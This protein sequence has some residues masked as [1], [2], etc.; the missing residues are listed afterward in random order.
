MNFSDFK[1]LI[2]PIKRKIFLSLGR[3]IL[4]AINNSEG[5]QKIQVIALSGETIT[6][7]ERFQEYGFET[8]PFI[9]AE[10]FAAFLNGN[11]DHGIVLCVHDR[12]YRPTDLVEGE[13]CNY[14]DE[15]QESGGHRIH[16][17]RGQIIEI[18]CKQ[19]IIN[20]VDKA[21]INTKQ[22][23]INATVQAKVTSPDTEVTGGTVKLA[24]QAGM[25]K[26]LNDNFATLYDGHQHG[27]GVV[28]DQSAGASHRTANVE[29]S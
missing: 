19:A 18:N 26:L 21:E 20:A 16:F 15:D 13:I 4:K 11:R 3:A 1:R 28:P 27:G 5:T 25:Q 24:S 23:N 29:G 6:D 8:Y 2:E 17:K 7:I 10:A 12:R 22:A 14:T 9:D